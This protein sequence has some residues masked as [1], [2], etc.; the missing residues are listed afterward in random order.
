MTQKRTVALAI[1]CALLVPFAVSCG[2]KKQVPPPPPT[3]RREAPPATTQPVPPEEP[4]TRPAEKEE[5]GDIRF[6]YD[7]FGLTATAQRILTEHAKAL[8][9]NT[10]WTV[11]IEGHC[12]ERGTVE[13]NLALGEKR[14]NA[15]R[16]FLVQ[17]GVPA[18]NVT[19]V[20]YGKERPKDS[21][22]NEEGWAINRRA[23]F[24]VK[25]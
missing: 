20:S 11:R 25:K 13:Y 17:Y 15:A 18:E 1:L 7:K 22:A 5:F 4:A 23:E 6:D 12:D 24:H 21:R 2:A 10:N 9:E 8:S 16:V 14:A 3:E 19:T